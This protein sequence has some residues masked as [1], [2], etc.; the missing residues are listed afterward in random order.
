MTCPPA[1]ES[2]EGKLYYATDKVS[3]AQYVSLFEERG[4]K[5]YLLAG[6]LEMQYM[7]LIEENKKC[8]FLRIDAD[9]A[10]ALKGDG[11]IM[12]NA[13][14]ADLFK[15]VS[16]N[17]QLKVTFGA[18]ADEGVPALLNLSEQ[19]RRYEDMM[20][21]YSRGESVKMPAMTEATLILN[22]NSPLIRRLADVSDEAM[23]E[24]AAKQIWSLS[25]LAQRQLTA[26]EL[27]SFLRQ[28][29]QTLGD[30]LK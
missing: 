25:L 26:E 17:G 16:G 5:V 11:E 21:Y 18:L 14:L 10:D 19:S 12:E 24:G 23:R 15:A 8:K 9:V 29:Y 7:G 20:R 27:K 22:S 13:S 30:A 2:H 1:K 6:P 28:S 4:I 3:Q